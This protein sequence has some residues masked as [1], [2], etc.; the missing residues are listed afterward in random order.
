MRGAIGDYF[1]LKLSRPE[2]LNR[3]GDNIVVFSFITLT[4]APEA[5][6]I[7]CSLP[8]YP[9]PLQRRT[10]HRQP[11]GILFINPWGAPCSTWA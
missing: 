8:V 1:K 11:G 2:I 9:R 6:Q 3:I 10:R 5:L 7:L 4:L